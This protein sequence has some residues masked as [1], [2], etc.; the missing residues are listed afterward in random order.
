MPDIPFTEKRAFP[1][2]PISIPLSY[3]DPNLC[4]VVNTKTYDI[5]AMGIGLVTDKELS[6]DTCLQI[7]LHMVD[8]GEK[9]NIKGKVAWVAKFAS[10]K[11][12]VGIKLEEK[13]KP[14]PLVLRSINFERKY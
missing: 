1:R 3:R 11:Y 2:F 4:S 10:D 9:I 5:S 13:L 12:R 6:P 14:I 7:C 8:N